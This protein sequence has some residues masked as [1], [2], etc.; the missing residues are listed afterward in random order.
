M[1]IIV[2][3]QDQ[4]KISHDVATGLCIICLLFGIAI[5]LPIIGFFASLF[6]PL[7]IIYY[8]I[9]LGANKGNI[10]PFGSAI[11]MAMVIGGISVD[12][13]Y[14][15]GLMLLGVILGNLL[16]YN[17]SLEKT[18]AYTCGT[19]LGIS[20]LC[21][22]FYSNLSNIGISGLVTDYITKNLELT[23][24]LYRSLN[25]PEELIAQVANALDQIKFVLV[26]ITPALIIAATLLVVW[27]NLILIKPILLRKNLYF[28]NFGN[29]NLWQAPE[30]LI[31]GLIGSGLVIIIPSPTIK[32]IGING[33]IIFCTIYF[34]QGMAIISFFLEKKNIPLP[35]KFI[36]YTIITIQQFFLF[37][38][39]GIGLFDMWFNF[40]KQ[41]T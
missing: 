1:V 9:K 37:I 35:V 25:V 23:L 5:Y 3:A 31:W 40:R 19:I 21:L 36:I 30:S 20:G 32:I 27:I 12:L 39:V 33:L 17:I 2:V 38:I 15:V 4:S 29:L 8:R 24:V 41:K 22:V 28:P 14:F 26:R 6:I 11:I 13:F 7:P 34:F 18:I 10:I 16:E